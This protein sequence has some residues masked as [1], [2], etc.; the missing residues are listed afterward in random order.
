[1]QQE[2]KQEQENT[3]LAYIN[4]VERDL[5]VVFYEYGHRYEIKTDKKSK[6]T[7]VTTWVHSHF[8]KFNADEVI[9]GMMCG[10]NW[11]PDNK[12]WGQSPDQIK[13][14]WN[15]NGA[16]ASRAGTKL[17]KH[18]ENF[19][20]MDEL[21]EEE[22]TNAF[23]HAMLIQHN[24]R[25]DVHNLSP[26][27]Q[28]RN[29]SKEWNYFIAF[30]EQNPD[31]VPYRTEWMVYDETLKFAGSID[32]VYINSDGSLSIYDWKR[33]KEIVKTNGFNKSA[34]TECIDYLPD[35]NFW[36]YSL[37]LNTYKMILERNYGRK[38]R[39]LKLVRLHPEAV[40]DN[41]EVLDV[42]IL[43]EEMKNLAEYRMAN[44]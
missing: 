6:Y 1:M 17:H 23:T 15:K 21:K 8:P 26:E 3:A 25:R 31:L 7:S 43:T 35:T 11:N 41:Y 28:A 40:H 34:T 29:A 39:E 24:L 18:I 16:D 19:M 20:N 2:Q 30:A 9:N 38:V 42:P 10:K 33:C 22:G 37:Q 5:Q 36:H 27:L 4:G 14:D 13:K 12:Y 32:M 44:L